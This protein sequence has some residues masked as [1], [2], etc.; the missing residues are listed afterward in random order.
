MF[1]IGEGKRRF[2]RK[3]VFYLVAPLFELAESFVADIH[4]TS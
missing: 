1:L 4:V 2:V 3:P